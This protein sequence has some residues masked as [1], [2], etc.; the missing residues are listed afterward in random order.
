MAMGGIQESDYQTDPGKLPSLLRQQK[1]NDATILGMRSSFGR[2]A[3]TNNVEDPLVVTFNKAKN[4]GKELADKIKNHPEFKK[5]MGG[6]LP[7]YQ[8]GAV[9]PASGSSNY[10]N[11]PSL[12]NESINQYK[13]QQFLNNKE[14][15]FSAP[16]STFNPYSVESWKFQQ[17]LDKDGAL[18]GNS[19]ELVSDQYTPAQNWNAQ[20]LAGK[21]NPN[22][23]SP[24]GN[25]QGNLGVQGPP[26]IEGK[27]F[28]YKKAAGNL[29]QFALQN[30]GN[31]YDLGRSTQDNSKLNLSRVSPT[32]LDKTQDL[33]NNLRLYSEGK[34]QTAE[35]SQGNASTYLSNMYA[36][37]ASKLANDLNINTTYGN[38]NASIDNAAKLY[39]AGAID[40]ETMFKLQAEGMNRN[41][42]GQALAG[43]SQNFL[44]QRNSDR[45]DALDQERLGLQKQYYKA[46]YDN[47]DREN[48][49]RVDEI[50]KGKSN[51]NLCIGG[52][53]FDNTGSSNQTQSTQST[54]FYFSQSQDSWNAMAKQQ[55]A[56]DKLKKGKK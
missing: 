2:N 8:D 53:C 32:F 18:Y 52:N 26:K 20:G 37:R 14:R 23:G 45:Q 43:M 17:Q 12:N 54:P 33:Q 1:A 3:D 41:L 39:N 56:Q 15:G 55:Q 36:N 21:I 31:I 10:F 11:T 34:R 48:Q 30:A 25:V 42:K 29:G 28:D 40:K 44:N 27:G 19:T 13:F 9:V 46:F 7:M 16:Q 5:E 35:A 24:S 6:K 49:R 47:Q 4:Y 38:L 22:A 51:S 50:T